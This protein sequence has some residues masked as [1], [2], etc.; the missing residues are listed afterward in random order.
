M[1]TAT[2]EK[3]MA[4]AMVTAQMLSHMGDLRSLPEHHNAHLG[5]WFRRPDSTGDCRAIPV[6]GS[7][8]TKGQLLTL[9]TGLIW[10]R[11]VPTYS[12]RDADAGEP[13]TLYRVMREAI[14]TQLRSRYEP[15]QVMPHELLVLVMQMND[16]KRRKQK[17]AS[18]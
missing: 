2:T 14:G 18:R 7:K 1:V 3:P 17:D 5:I 9:L 16:E 13:V 4:N 10:R 8:G 6:A 12:R 11:T 15:P